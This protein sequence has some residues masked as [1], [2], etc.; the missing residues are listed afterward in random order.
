MKFS[1]LVC[2][3]N[4]ATNIQD[5]LEN[6]RNLDVPKGIDFSIH[7][8]DN[9]STD[10]T[11]ILVKRIAIMPGAPVFLHILKPI[12]KCAAL[13]WGFEHLPA[14]YYLL[15]DAN[16]IFGSDVLQVFN[17]SLR[18]H[19]ECGLFVGNTRTVDSRKIGDVFLANKEAQLPARLRLEQCFDMFTGANGG[20]YGVS[21]NAVQDIWKYPAVRNDDFI[22]SVYAAIRASVCYMKEAKAFE[23]EKMTAARLFYQ[24]YRDALGHHQAIR[25][26]QK[27]CKNTLQGR[28]IVIL[29]LCYWAQPLLVVA[30]GCL[31]I[32]PL[33]TGTIGLLLQIVPKI[34]RVTVRTGGLYIGYLLGSINPPPVR[35]DT[36]R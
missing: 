13:F 4:E 5:R 14:D 21:S 31:V 36:K 32:G 16:T 24:K 1:L 9:G 35:W 2:T 22:I 7:V 28:L 20:C 26:I 6:L 10:D 19:P 15:T 27:N 12:G 8:L 34:R 29:R 30:V 11:C 23:I 17:D 33:V 18:D 3:L 25:W